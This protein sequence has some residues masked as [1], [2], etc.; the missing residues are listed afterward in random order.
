MLFSRGK[1]NLIKLIRGA[2]DDLRLASMKVRVAKGIVN[3]VRRSRVDKLLLQTAFA[4]FPI[5]SHFFA[6]MYASSSLESIRK[7]IKK[8]RRAEEVINERYPHLYLTVVKE[9]LNPCIGRLEELLGSKERLS[10][11]EVIKVVDEVSTQLSVMLNYVEEVIQ[12]Y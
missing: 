4:G 8:L 1:G 3:E 6:N 9:V 12:D 10:G 5:P 7:A 2:I 11:D